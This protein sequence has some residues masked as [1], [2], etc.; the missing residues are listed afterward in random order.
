MSSSETGGGG[1]GGGGS[2]LITGCFKVVVLVRGEEFA[3]LGKVLGGLE[4]GLGSGDGGGNGGDNGG[5]GGGDSGGGGGG[6]RK[7]PS[8][9][10]TKGVNRVVEVEEMVRTRARGKQRRTA[11]KRER[12]L[13]ESI[14]L[15]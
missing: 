6:E 10:L 11:Q 2:C 1:G 12:G 13:G 4:M 14:S 15:V 5:G 7:A 8:L 9:Q 3:F